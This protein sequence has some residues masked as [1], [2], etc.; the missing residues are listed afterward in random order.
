MLHLYFQKIATIKRVHTCWIGAAIER[1]VAWLN[2]QGYASK[3]ITIRVPLLMRFGEFTN[4][5]G[6]RN[7]SELPAQIEP[8]VAH[9]L[10]R[11]GRP[12]T[13]NY[14]IRV[15]ARWIRN[16]ISQMLRLVLPG[17]RVPGRSLYSDPFT[18]T[19]PDF[20]AFLRKQRG[21][22][23]TTLNQYRH[24]LRRLE[25][26]L[27]RKNVPMLSQLSAGVI[28]AF[29]TET[30]DGVDKR[31]VQSRCSILKVFLRYLYSSGELARDLSQQIESP[32][33]YSLA[34]LPRAISWDAVRRM[35]E[36][37]DTSDPTGKRDYAILLLLVTYGLRAREVSALTLDDIDWE[38]E[39]FR[40][41]KRKGGHSAVYPLSATVGNSILA[42]LQTG[43]PACRSRALFL[44]AFAPIGPMSWNAVALRA[45]QY[46]RKAAIEVPHPGSHTLRHTCVQRL[47]D[48]RQSLKIIGDYVGHRTPDATK[49]YTKV[50][51]ET[52]REVALGVGEEVL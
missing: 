37:V 28:S 34:H 50:D 21:L 40:I 51:I 22:Q 17:F 13:C 42:Y 49:I 1:Y 39:R 52:L 23:E 14:Q 16:P 27:G 29:I 45:K 7:W 9:W 12:K 4:V 31:S 41:P 32:R 10:S 24:H 2:E 11:R 15:A 43:R 8:F 30:S 47:V 20:F 48:A 3:T 44:R 33:R 18:D 36:T 25:E 46:L 38:R 26:Y 19:L 35:L 5:R 6:V